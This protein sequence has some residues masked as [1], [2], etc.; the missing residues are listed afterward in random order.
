MQPYGPGQALGALLENYRTSRNLMTALGAVPPQ[1]KLQALALL[2]VAPLAADI[3]A[4][5]HVS[6]AQIADVGSSSPQLASLLRAEE[7]LIPAQKAS[8]NEWKRWWWFCAAGMLMFFLLV[9]KMRGRWSPRA[10][11]RDFE[12]HERLVTEELAK[13]RLQ[14]APAGAGDLW[15]KQETVLAGRSTHLPVGTG[16]LALGPD[17]VDFIEWN[18]DDGKLIG[19][20]QAVTTAGQVPYLSTTSDT[21]RVVGTLHGSVVTLSFD[22]D[23]P[24]FGALSDGCLVL[25]CT[26]PDG[27]LSPLTFDS[28]SASQYN[29]A[30]ADLNQRVAQANQKAA[31]GPLVHNPARR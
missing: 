9:F 28:A 30:V 7:K 8:P 26:Q 31:N 20:V 16:Y 17:F 13:L 29:S 27:T 1:L 11:K 3:Q 22:S 23:P 2:S 15:T 24:T 25:D 18:D 19:F 21:V 6:A 12:E 14:I 4:G 5:K 10:A